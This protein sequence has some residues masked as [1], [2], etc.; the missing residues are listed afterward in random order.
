M[1]GDLQAKFSSVTG[2]AEFTF[3]I[4]IL[5][6]SEVRAVSWGRFPIFIILNTEMIEDD[7]NKETVDIRKELD[8][9][10]KKFDRC[11][12]SLISTLKVLNWWRCR[13]M[14]YN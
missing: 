2:R 7:E 13:W 3:Q 11:I 6:P 5:G 1:L 12:I 4:W 8:E 10:D 9:I 14:W